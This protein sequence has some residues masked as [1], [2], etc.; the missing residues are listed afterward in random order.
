[1]RKVL[2][3]VFSYLPFL[4]SCSEDINKILI[5][6]FLCLKIFSGFLAVLKTG[7]TTLHLMDRV[8]LENIFLSILLKVCASSWIC[9]AFTMHL[10]FPKTSLG[11][12][13]FLPHLHLAKF[14]SLFISTYMSCPLEVVFCLLQPWEYALPRH[15]S[16]SALYLV[17][18]PFVT[19]YG[20]DLIADCFC[21]G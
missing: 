10:L 16:Q 21:I 17:K 12:F 7:K 14:Y 20:N 9:Q 1:M 3:A 2:L 15:I 19:M 6:V 13:S 4:N 5:I 11:S 8:W 18:S